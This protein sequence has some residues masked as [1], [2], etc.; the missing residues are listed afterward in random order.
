MKF[1]IT[2]ILLVTIIG[3]TV[4]FIGCSD[5]ESN[6]KSDEVKLKT[7][8]ADKL[9]DANNEDSVFQ[10]IGTEIY[11]L[12]INQTA[13]KQALEIIA[14]T[15][16]GLFKYNQDHTIG[17]GLCKAYELSE[18][19]LEYIFYLRTDS[20][21]SNGDPVT[22]H[23]FVYS[24]K[25]LANSKNSIHANKIALT[26]IKSSFKTAQAENNVNTDQLGVEALND[27][28]LK[29]VLEKPNPYLKSLLTLPYFAPLN[30]NFVNKAGD[31]YGSTLDTVL[32]NGPYIVSVWEPE[33]QYVLS[34]NNDYYNNEEV[35]LENIVYKIIGTNENAAL[36][37]EENEID[38]LE[39]Q[40]E[41]QLDY[42]SNPNT[43]TILE[44]TVYYITL[45]NN[46]EILKNQN[47]RKAFALA[48][49]KLYIVENF[50]KDGSI[51]IDN[52]VPYGL[53]FD[54]NGEDFHS[55]SIDDNYYYD[56]IKARE[57]WE[58]AKEELKLDTYELIFVIAKSE[59]ST[60]IAE[61]I[62]KEFQ[63]N[64]E[65]LSIVISP[66]KFSSSIESFEIYEKRA[67]EIE[68][69]RA[70]YNDP[71]A[72]LEIWASDSP[73]NNAGYSSVEFDKIISKDKQGL[74]M[75]NND[76][77]WQELK[78]AEKLLVEEDVCIIPMFQ[79]GQSIL[80]NP[81]IKRLDKY[82]CEDLILYMHIE[83]E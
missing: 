15:I 59:F 66:T 40:Q 36:M 38:Y 30:E 20:R 63:E 3:L 21:W 52:I 13:N 74:F 23:D 8:S 53:S 47:A 34:R 57:Y 25:R 11:T 28:T 10:R 67:M 31:A 49:D 77:R 76:I 42:T 78:R 80:L 65:E 22:A 60:A 48:L 43:A 4:F 14:N 1:R 9:H 51:L 16:E 35:E 12:D 5:S 71:L 29:V 24:W 19:G 62:Q 68:G 44:T 83:M 41:S 18:D 50:T 81:A 7:D 45:N 32:S 64:F 6:E 2:I 56:P 26:Q 82:S 46:N 27:Y 69:W 75:N 37:Y 39:L 72:M 58:R 70:D 55:T 73:Y 79:V 17:Y 54:S 33:E 61:Y